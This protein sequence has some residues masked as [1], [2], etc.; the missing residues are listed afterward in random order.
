MQDYTVLVLRPAMAQPGSALV[1][2]LW[3]CQ[4]I[5]RSHLVGRGLS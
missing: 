5:R 1:I 3:G 2:R 4:A